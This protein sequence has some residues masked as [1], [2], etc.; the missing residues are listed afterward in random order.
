MSLI[1]VYYNIRSISPLGDILIHAGD[2]TNYGL[3]SEIVA[4][5]DWLA[6]LP[7]KVNIEY[8]NTPS[9][10]DYFL[11][12]FS[13]KLWSPVT[14]NHELSFDPGTLEESRY[15]MRQVGEDRDTTKVVTN[16]MMMLEIETQLSCDGHCKP[17]LNI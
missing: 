3:V 6:K 12:I 1:L 14:G 17:P 13:I 4:F 10:S 15:Y 2:F 9:E 8:M 16:I 11:V 5:N 7:H